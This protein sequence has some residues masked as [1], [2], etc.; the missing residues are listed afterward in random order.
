MKIWRSKAPAVGQS[1]DVSIFRAQP[2]HVIREIGGSGNK[3]RYRGCRRREKSRP[4]LVFKTTTTFSFFAK[5]YGIH[6]EYSTTRYEQ[7]FWKMWIPECAEKRIRKNNRTIEHLRTRHY[8]I[9]IRPTNDK[10]LNIHVVVLIR[11]HLWRSFHFFFRAPNI[12]WAD[13]IY[14]HLVLV[15]RRWIQN[16]RMIIPKTTDARHQ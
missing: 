1:R 15:V 16:C 4:T 12:R 9:M 10:K 5:N 7:T 13:R 3:E 8:T 6:F 14:E 2:C 11:T